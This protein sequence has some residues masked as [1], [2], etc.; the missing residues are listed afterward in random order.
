MDGTIFGG[1]GEMINYFFQTDV[2]VVDLTYPR[3]VKLLCSAV[4]KP[5]SPF[6]ACATLNALNNYKIYIIKKY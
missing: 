1:G 4:D 3:S 6:K 5:P 2:G